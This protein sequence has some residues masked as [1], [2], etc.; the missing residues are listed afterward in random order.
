M[1]ASKTNEEIPFLQSKMEFFAY[2]K[3]RASAIKEF[4]K[5][6]DDLKLIAR[7]E[8]VDG[9]LY[10][11]EDGCYVDYYRMKEMLKAFTDK[12]EKELGGTK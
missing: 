2:E 9:K 8:L 6:I 1:N 7:F 12:F 11:K 4:K 5:F 10:M 3:G